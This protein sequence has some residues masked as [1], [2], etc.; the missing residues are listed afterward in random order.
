MATERALHN[1]DLMVLASSLDHRKV[2]VRPQDT[3]PVNKKYHVREQ[4]GKGTFGKVYRGYRK[5]D[6]STVAMKFVKVGS[7]PEVNNRERTLLSSLRHDCIV[8]LA[9]LF[10]AGAFGP[11]RYASP[12]V[13][14]RSLHAIH[15]FVG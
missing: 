4:I 11:S 6:G 14:L 12:R 3:D 2:L 5:S 9:G 1:Q 8:F 10:R 7:D 13:L 15:P